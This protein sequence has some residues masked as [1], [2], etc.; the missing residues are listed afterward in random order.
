MLFV[1]NYLE[2]IFTHKDNLKTMLDK[3]LKEIT[4]TMNKFGEFRS[5]R[6]DKGSEWY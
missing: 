6:S 1:L 4:G 5:S 3:H 2:P